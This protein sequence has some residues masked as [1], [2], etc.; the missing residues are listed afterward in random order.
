MNAFAEI[1][2]REGETH[3]E[4]PVEST[5]A[6]S[7]SVPKTVGSRAWYRR[8]G[9]VVVIAACLTALGALGVGSSIGATASTTRSAS[10]SAVT[11]PVQSSVQSSYREGELA[12]GNGQSGGY[13]NPYGTAA[14]TTQATA[15]TASERESTGIVLIETVLGYQDAAA[16]GTGMVLSSGGL[17]L[18]NNHVVAGSTQIAV[19]IA[20]TGETY[21]AKVVGTDATHDVALLQLQGASGLDT[22][23]IDHD[24]TENAGDVVTA[25]G[26]AHGGGV[27][28]AADG[29][30]TKLDSTVTTA[31]E[32][33]ARGRPSTASSRSRHRS[34]RVTRAARC[35]MRT[36]RSSE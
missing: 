16:A 18:T 26:N 20:S 1:S 22:I 4:Q 3:H 24:D 34:C 25:V 31:A 28:M 19:T 21:I 29:T 9:R 23:A 11:L 32:G 6:S 36:A 7:S 12:D 15:T 27:L 30:I 2:A 35:S 8:P 14:T 17:V 13:R 5:D 33:A 10:A